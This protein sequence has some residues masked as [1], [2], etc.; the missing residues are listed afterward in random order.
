MSQTCKCNC[1][2]DWQTE[3]ADVIV[4]AEEAV[5]HIAPGN[6]V[7]VGT[8]C[9]QPLALL[10]ALV[11]RANSLADVEITHML[12]LG[13]A[14]YAN[15]ELSQHFMVNSFFIAENVR[16]VIQAGFGD[17]TPISLS[18]LPRLFSSG[19]LPLDAALIQVS[20][21]DEYGMCSL[22]ISVDI[23]KSAAANAKIVIAQV[24]PQMPR[25]LGN[26][27]I[28][29]HDIDYLVSLDTPIIEVKW[30]ESDEVTRQIG[31]HVA[32]LVEDA[33]TLELGIGRLPHAV[34]ECLKDK[35][36]LGIHSEMITDGVIDLIES[37]AINGKFKSLD[38][39][40][41]VA[42]FCM[43]TRRLYDY[44]DNNP[45]FA[46]HPTEYVNNPTV[47]ERQKKMV[48]INVGQ[49]IGLTGQVS[50][51]TLDARFYS[52]MG[53]QLDF[54]RGAAC[55]D[56]GKVIIVLPST[57]D[58]GKTSRIRTYLAPGSGVGMTRSDVHYVVT[59]YGVAYL[60]GKN[61]QERALALISIANPKFRAE[62]IREAVKAKF[63]RPEM[64]EVDDFVVGPQE[65]KTSLL[66]EDGT[67]IGFRAIH[68]TDEAR[69]RDLIYGLSSET[70]YNRFMTHTKWLSREE[71]QNFVY[72]DH[73]NEVAIV[74]T[75]PEAFGEDIIAVGRYNLDP[76]TNRAEV[77]FIVDDTWQGRGIGTF[78]LGH[79]ITV[80]KRNGLAGFRAEM[81]PGNKAMESV[82]HKSGCKVKSQVKGDVTFFELDF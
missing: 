42:S 21:P 47:I 72:I 66:L 34:L 52:G 67:Q 50:V 31:Q 81:L 10:R 74:G 49:E 55:S 78:L 25:T 76:K 23:V 68:P 71:V 7:F 17:Y 18:D 46:F 9:A 57:T 35:K 19:Q 65:L 6:R 63:V 8:G 64:A 77:A 51:D 61:V 40:Q 41:I 3:Y 1:C 2:P 39:G 28:H 27:T 43:G 24:N 11:A 29:I 20:P 82:F 32:S 16:E 70:L 22:G 69:I 4:T 26:S 59:E 44:I 80:A 56:G 33:S 58:D 54:S 38:R 45:L 14:P 37:G 13:D 73:R 79:L 75:L 36:D 30:A 60:H 12:T 15:K 5:T 62:L 48:S 53:G